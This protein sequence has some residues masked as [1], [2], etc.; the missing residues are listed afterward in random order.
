MTQ[1]SDRIAQLWP[2]IFMGLGACGCLGVGLAPKVNVRNLTPYVAGLALLWAMAATG[3]SD[4]ISPL[5]RYVNYAVTGV[6]LLLLL[7]AVGV[8]ES[9]MTTITAERRCLAGRPFDP[10]DAMR[11]EFYAFFLLSL[12]GVML[13]GGANDLA[14]LF[15]SLELVS[16]PTYI[17]VATSRDAVDARESAVKYFFLGA[18]AVAV[19]LYGFALIY[20]VT[21]T[22]V[23]TAPPG[24]AS[25]AG[26][27]Q[28]L[29]EAGQPLP[30]LLV[31]GLMLAVVGLAFKIAAV[32][33]HFY[34]AD[35]YQGAATPVTAFL[36][37][38]P[39]TAG[40]VSL[41]LLLNA[42]G[43][44]WPAPVA[45]ALSLMA[46]L[47]MSVGN[48]LG[49]LQ[50]NVK[51]ILAYSSIAHSGYMIVGLLAVGETIDRGGAL[52]DGAAAVLFYLVAYGLGNL[53]AFAVLASLRT[54]GE[55]A[56][57][58]EDITGLARRAPVLAAIML[59]AMLSLIGLPPMIGFLGK[60]YLF[61]SAIEH[62]YVLLVVIAV[63]NSAVSAVYY[64][65]IAS[66]CYFGEPA[67]ADELEGTQPLGAPGRLI[68]GGLA[69]AA[70]LG[71]GVVGGS[72]VS[73]A[74]S[75]AVAIG[76]P[77]P[78]A[79]VQSVKKT[80]KANEIHP[81]ESAVDTIDTADGG[82]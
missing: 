18:M 56:Q 45:A 23:F 24:E 57:T 47:T 65:R 38:V 72:L 66:A 1:M 69:A 54:R 5:G 81:T 28:A 78:R 61:G 67:G 73:G 58:L 20:G 25:I 21:G 43:G 2:E 29:R 50:T 13:C 49:L 19:F 26:Y 14:W 41:I 35:V 70:A 71:L 82:W 74:H 22:T 64:L 46:V 34:T 8:P 33:M 79:E 11:G 62:G 44:A 10:G 12:A 27:I 32:P 52:G 36:A 75:A 4:T 16:L 55:E 53:A 63:L 39:K 68:A 7:V 31:M 30:P 6:G 17:M 3:F 80:A 60:I 51:R 37:F 42:F 77:F 15:L 40:F 59:L 48:V 76:E 9:L